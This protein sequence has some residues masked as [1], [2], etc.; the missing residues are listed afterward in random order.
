VQ[1]GEQVINVVH[2][3]PEIG[4]V[5]GTAVGAFAFGFDAADQ[6]LQFGEIKAAEGDRRV[7]IEMLPEQQ[8]A[9][10]RSQHHQSFG[11]DA[12]RDPLRI[13][14]V[15]LRGNRKQRRDEPKRT[16]K[17]EMRGDPALQILRGVGAGMHR[18]LDLGLQPC[19]LVKADLQIR[20]QQILRTPLRDGFHPRTLIQRKCCPQAIL[21]AGRRTWRKPGEEIVE[22]RGVVAAREIA[23][24]LEPDLRE[25][26]PVALG[27][28]LARTLQSIEGRVYGCDQAPQP[29][30]R[31]E[32]AT[33]QQHPPECPD[34]MTQ[35]PLLL[36]NVAEPVAQIL[37]AYR[38]ACLAR[39]PRGKRAPVRTLAGNCADA[40]GEARVTLGD[41][42]IADDPVV[43]RD[44]GRD[45]RRARL[46]R[47]G[48]GHVRASYRKW[49]ALPM[50]SIRYAVPAVVCAAAAY[51][52]L[53]PVRDQPLAF[54]PARNPGMTGQFV[55]NEALRG[56]Q[57]VAEGLGQWPEDVARAAD[58][59]FYTGLQDGRIVRFRGGGVAPE[60]FVQ[61]GGRP[62][63]L[64]FDRAG[65]LIVAD[66]FRGLLSVS[67]GGKVSILADSAEGEKL[68]FVNDLDIA[69]D[70]AV[71]FSN[72][73]QRFDQHRWRRDFLETRPTGSLLRYDPA[74][75]RTS[76]ALR[77][78]MFANGVAV[79][80]N[81]DF[82]LVTETVAARVVR[83][84]LRG[85]DAGKREVFLEL[86]GYPDNVSFN[87]TD[88]FW[89]ALGAPRS[90]AIEWTWDLPGV[91]RILARLPDATLHLATPPPYSWVIAVDVHGR[92]VHNL[93]DS[94]GGCGTV[95]SANEFDRTLYLGSIT[96]N[97]ISRYT[98]R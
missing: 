41:P 55:A 85:P 73:S 8:H 9:A 48:A 23:R 54:T 2:P 47:F 33:P 28:S 10:G 38:A 39:G 51:L 93:Q 45:L 26:F 19:L 67:T 60:T 78:L 18:A 17:P 62:L 22:R 42:Q 61:T 11:N 50:R 64:Q 21:P 77:G 53:W 1:S 88:T 31:I 59:F 98:L 29:S 69:P 56:S 15:P 79:G 7:R 57:R 74:T 20:S 32:Q 95:S 71:W 24:E 58:G 5:L 52:L 97:S 46:C 87:G 63:G 91:R 81:G 12:P 75:G 86:P 94:R 49:K 83:L 37:P 40:C 82:V 65:N 44:D 25:H 80:P 92:V 3:L 96:A 84:W 43:Q 34:R 70:G 89:I 36:R 16:A 4:P 6:L 90:G 35:A 66:A 13:P 27:D 76:V 72:A 68:L 14:P 30:V